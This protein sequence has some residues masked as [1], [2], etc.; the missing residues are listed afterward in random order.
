MRFLTE[1]IYAR[2]DAFVSLKQELLALMDQEQD[3]TTHGQ[4]I[5]LIRKL[6][7]DRYMSGPV[8]RFLTEGRTINSEEVVKQL[9]IT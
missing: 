6:I 9:L 3:E 7:S 8:D 5:D 2:R 4:I 1:G